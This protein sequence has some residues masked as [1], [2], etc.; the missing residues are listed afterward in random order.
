MAASRET[1]SETQG[2]PPYVRTSPICS[3]NSM[4][5]CSRPHVP[6]SE[7][8]LRLLLVD[9]IEEF[10][11]RCFDARMVVLASAALA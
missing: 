1:N 3:P 8:R 11:F 10:F 4:E 5:A 6:E 2:Q 9:P 7:F